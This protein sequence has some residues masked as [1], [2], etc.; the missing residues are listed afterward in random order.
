MC[1]ASG[2]APEAD[3]QTLVCDNRPAARI[4][5]ADASP[6]FTLF[7]WISTKSGP[8]A[9]AI[10]S[11]TTQTSSWQPRQHSP[12]HAHT[13]TRACKPTLATSILCRG[14][15]VARRARH[16]D[17]LFGRHAGEQRAELDAGCEAASLGVSKP[18][19][20]NDS[21]T[22]PASPILHVLDV[23]FDNV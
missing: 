19:A 22:P 11:V 3:E 5:C 7:G 2:P 15:R 16:D 4:A 20:I 23:W 12:T 6:C 17:A 10:A 13:N 21:M 8:I 1:R 18:A 9:H 14:E